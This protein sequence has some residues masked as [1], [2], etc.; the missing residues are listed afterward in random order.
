[1]R[2]KGVFLLIFVAAFC[3]GQNKSVIN[4]DSTF[5]RVK[6][7]TQRLDSLCDKIAFQKVYPRFA[8]IGTQGFSYFGRAKLKYYNSTNVSIRHKIK[9]R[10]T[11]GFRY[12]KDIY[13]YENNQKIT[14]VSVNDKEATIIWRRTGMKTGTAEK[15]KMV[16][17]DDSTMVWS[18]IRNEVTLAP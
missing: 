10:H 6:I 17:V 13:W 15:I 5:A 8:F 18:S 9:I 1:M 7:Q 16:R 3:S 12:K 2:I 11:G 4:S 14:V